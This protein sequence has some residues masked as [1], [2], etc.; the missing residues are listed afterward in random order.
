VAAAGISM[1]L[2]LILGGGAA[3]FGGISGSRA[4]AKHSLEED[5]VLRVA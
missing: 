1:F 4:N 5:E 3:I 2:L